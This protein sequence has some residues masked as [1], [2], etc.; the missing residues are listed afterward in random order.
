MVFDRLFNNHVLDISA[1]NKRVQ[2]AVV[3]EL[4]AFQRAR[5]ERDATTTAAFNRVA[6]ELRNVAESNNKIAAAMQAANTT[7]KEQ[8]SEII[9][10]LQQLI[11][12]QQT[13][14]LKMFQ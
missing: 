9:R 10:N 13:M 14:I 12:N 3:N 8:N 4:T 7:T 2:P 5:L 6:D 1:H 11:E